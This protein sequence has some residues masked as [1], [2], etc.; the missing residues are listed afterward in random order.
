MVSGM[1]LGQ[2][3][4]DLTTDSS[5]LDKGLEQSRQKGADWSKGIALAVGGIGLAIAGIGVAAFKLGGEFD[6]AFDGIRAGTGK[7]GVDLETLKE[8]FRAVASTVATD[9]G[10]ASSVITE[11]NKRTGLMGEGLQTVAAQV[12]NMAK[13]TGEDAATSVAN[14]TRLFGDW[15][16]STE[17]Q[18]GSLDMVFRAS[19]ATG[20]GVNDLMGRL[21]QFG[22][23]L[24]QFGFGVEEAAA[25]M[26]K[27]EKEGVNSELVLG[28]LR[29]AMGKFA[30]DGIPMRQGLDDTIKKIQKLG[31][32]ANA[33][34]LAMDIFGARAGPDMA[35]AILE[36]RFEL[37][38]LLDQVKNGEDTIA[39]LTGET[40]DLA[41]K[42]QKFTN[43]AA[44]AAEPLANAVFSMAG[45]ILDVLAPALETV[46]SWFSSFT[47][48]IGFVLEEG[49]YLN[50]W[51]A[52]LPGPLR[53]IAQVMGMVVYYFQEAYQALQ[54][55]FGYLSPD[56]TRDLMREWFGDFGPQID[57][58]VLGIKGLGTTVGEVFGSLAEVV[59]YLVTGDFQGGIFGLFEDEEPILMLGQ[60]RD[61]FSSLWEIARYLVTGDYRGGIF[62]MFEDEEPI[63]WLFNFRDAMGNLVEM[64]KA[65]LQPILAGLAAVLAAVVIPAIWAWVAAQVAAGAAAV[66]AGAAAIAALL[67]VVIPLVAIGVAVA[68]LYKAWE[69]NWG[70]IRGKTQA[71]WDYIQPILQAV[72]DKL[73]IFWTEIQPKL[74]A[75]WDNIQQTV[76]AAWDFLWNQVLKPGMALLVAFWKD[77]WETIQAALQGVWQIIEGI[78]QV[79]WAIVSGII[80]TGL[81]LLSGD[82]EG[83]WTAIKEMF[84]GIWNG[85]RTFVEGWIGLFTSFLLLAWAAIGDHVTAAWNAIKGFIVGILDAISQFLTDSWIAIQSVAQAAWD[86]FVGLLKAAWNAVAGVINFYIAA[87]ELALQVAWAVIYTAAQLFWDTFGEY[88][89]AIWET[90]SGFISTTLNTIQGALNTAWT[91]ISGVATIAWDAVK[92]YFQGWWD[93]LSKTVDTAVEAIKGALT[94]AWT[95]VRDTTG[96]L[97]SAIA[98]FIGEQIDNAADRVSSGLDKIRGWFSAAANAIRGIVEPLFN[99]VS[100]WFQNMILT[101]QGALG[102]I[103]DM[104]QKVQDALG[105][106][107]DIVQRARD[108]VGSIPGAPTLDRVPTYDLGGIIPGPIGIP[109]LAMV[110]GGEEVLT[111]SQRQERSGNVTNYYLTAQYAYQDERTLGQEIR[112]L[113]LLGSA[114]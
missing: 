63:L 13:L 49:D 12:I 96:T 58:F 53:G 92:A 68:L 9:F 33:T 65:N 22:A 4:L 40:E 88:I 34:A 42:W 11:L 112:L 57:Q 94:G 7:S 67:P 97:W 101:A 89:T 17:D 5:G 109:V 93:W 105:V 61:A 56:N 55:F 18:A 16:I 90:V 91:A 23:P 51:L 107:A 71:A 79:A 27:W 60:F 2:A 26:G 36:G 38:G 59:R 35:A 30:K 15:S 86:G 114:T 19:Q 44:L 14:V 74:Q 47:K 24:R 32:S 52:D 85:I 31:P 111:P 77:N 37:G 106:I 75:A 50:D 95:V 28:S 82:W 113:Q 102:G 25:L 80:N 66:A 10:T 3:V 98:G 1:S 41:E 69:S 84:T 76:K 43:R 21:V 48:Y 108:L 45:S 104:V 54:A 29:I 72:L 70:D 8:D 78:V 20:I 83:A 62:G 64:V 99:A 6:A 73:A 46:I 39:G 100:G 103:Q 110:H 81:A 87:V